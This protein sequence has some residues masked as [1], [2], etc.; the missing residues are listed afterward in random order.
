MVVLLR[1]FCFLNPTFPRLCS[2]IS[3]NFSALELPA[4]VKTSLCFHHAKNSKIIW[5]VYLYLERLVQVDKHSISHNLERLQSKEMGIHMAKM[6]AIH[7][8]QK[9]GIQ[10]YKQCEWMIIN[11]TL[12]SVTF[13]RFISVAANL[14][15]KPG[16][17]QN[18]NLFL[19]YRYQFLLRK[20]L[21]WRVNC[22]P[23]GP[24]L[25]QTPLSPGSPN[26][27]YLLIHTWQPTHVPRCIP[28]LH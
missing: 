1:S 4:L 20:W 14:H 19:H 9:Q 5:V 11:N 28:S 13:K 10:T 15:L 7:S 27:Q 16:I 2:Q 3:R 26:L 18:Y 6:T 12:H 21:L 25:P 24:S 17:S 8:Y 23:W 22:T